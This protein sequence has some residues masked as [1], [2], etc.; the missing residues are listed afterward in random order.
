LEVYYS[1]EL[2]R[3]QTFI[4]RFGFLY[5]CYK[6]GAKDLDSVLF[7]R[8]AGVSGMLL[9]ETPDTDPQFSTNGDYLWAKFIAYERLLNC[10]ADELE[11]LRGGAQPSATP[12]APLPAGSLKWTG[13]TINLVELSYGIWLTGQFNNGQASITEIVEF[14]EAAF[15][16]RIGKPHRRWQGL[17]GRK[18]LGY[19]RFLDEMKASIEKRV[20]E[21][22]GR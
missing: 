20:E 21:E 14:L 4:N 7:L 6:I 1:E 2:K 9:P 13:E 12:A 10:L 11:Q 19:I 17:A 3:L 22:M 8:D 15:R 16:V 5:Q 18:R